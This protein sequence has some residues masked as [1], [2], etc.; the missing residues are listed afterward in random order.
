MKNAELSKRLDNQSENEQKAS[1]FLQE[2]ILQ[3]YL[4]TEL[5]DQ[6]ANQDRIDKME[7]GFIKT[8]SNER[9]ALADRKKNYQRR[10]KKAITL[11]EISDNLLDGDDE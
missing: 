6:N 7:R 9:V 1:A 11:E 8:V 2:G 5:K 3:N 10:W 4:L